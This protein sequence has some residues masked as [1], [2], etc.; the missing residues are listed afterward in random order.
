MTRS[1]RNKRSKSQTTSD[2]EQQQQ[3]QQHEGGGERG[4]KVFPSSY[5]L[6]TYDVMCGRNKVA[7]GHGGNKRFRALVE[8][9]CLHYMKEETTREER[10][11]IVT[12]ILDQVVAKGGYFLKQ[13]YEGGDLQEISIKY[14]RE[15]IV[16]SLRDTCLKLQAMMEV[17]SS[18]ET[19]P[20]STTK[21]KKET[22]PS[23]KSPTNSSHHAQDLKYTASLST[24]Q[25]QDSEED[26]TSI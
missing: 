21:T 12:H 3:Q 5:S 13:D 19:P 4:L 9:H 6:A 10:R 18:K 1:K 16:H 11:S 23:K 15:K 8:K 7:E 24:T 25:T 14:A 22:V 17:D 26:S 20:L 2:E